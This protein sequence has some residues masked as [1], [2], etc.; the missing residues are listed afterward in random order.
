MKTLLFPLLIL[1]LLLSCKKKEITFEIQGKV[2]DAT[3]SKALSGA[4]YRIYTQPVSGVESETL[5]TGTLDSNGEFESVFPRKL[6][7]KV[8]VEIKKQGYF[9]VLE[10]IVFDKLSTN[11]AYKF[12]KST[13]AQA[14]VKIRIVNDSPYEETDHLRFIKQEGKINCV[15]CCDTAYHNLYGKVDTTLYCINDG[16][17][18]YSMMYWVLKTGETGVKSVVTNAFDT[19]EIQLNY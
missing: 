4:S 6:S 13:T 5:A 19:T 7:Q 9:T 11:E 10:E 3:F 2:T 14:W 16:N 15:N 12:S 17:K 1:S 18:P 8:I